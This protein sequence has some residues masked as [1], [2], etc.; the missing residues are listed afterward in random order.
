MIITCEKCSKTF[1]IDDKLI[2]NEGRLLQCGSCNY[3]WFFKLTNEINNSENEANK[4]SSKN[5]IFASNDNIKKIQLNEINEEIKDTKKTK[6]NNKNVNLKNKNKI[7]KNSFV[8]I[9]SIIAL[10]VLV[11]TFKH[12]LNSYVPGINL[13][14]NNL[15]ESLKDLSLFF[16]DLVN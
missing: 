14:L 10:I 5:E 16:I 8:F 11:D 15:Y 2:P 6:I 1:N 7:I 12:Q 3:K 4:S 13:I 9:I